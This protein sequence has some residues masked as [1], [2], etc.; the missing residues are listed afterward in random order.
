MSEQPNQPTPNA[1]ETPKK[2][3][4]QRRPMTEM[5]RMQARKR[6]DIA[7]KKKAQELKE[8]TAE[9]KEA[10]YQQ[11]HA[12]H[13]AYEQTVELKPK[14]FQE[15]WANYWYHYKGRTFFIAFIVLLAALFIYD[16]VNK[17]NYD[18]DIMAITTAEHSVLSYEETLALLGEVVP[19]FNGD[20]KT[21]VS[22]DA[23][24]LS[25]DSSET[26]DPNFH[27]AQVVKYQANIGDTVSL[28]LILDQEN[29][30]AMIEQE[31]TFIDLSK[32]TNNPNVVGD[33]YY[34][35]NNPCFKNLLNA[36]SLIMVFRDVENST[37][38]DDEKTRQRAAE[39]LEFV[40]TLMNQDLSAQQ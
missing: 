30:D 21:S 18:V 1:P 22:I 19:D 29:Y 37:K 11:A 31:I 32:Y 26:L 7:F 3:S 5:E 4:V 27:M 9:Q 8:A 40:K 14:T 35:K 39:E 10:I 20:G 13:L 33:K 23:I 2:A 6:R 25:E 16:M 12:K 15:K 24:Q 38:S 28:I 34:L 36:D 17:E